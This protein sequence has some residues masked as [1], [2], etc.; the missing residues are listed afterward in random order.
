MGTDKLL[1]L[2]QQLFNR[3]SDRLR[4]VK[5]YAYRV[6]GSRASLVAAFH[7]APIIRNPSTLVFYFGES[8]SLAVCPIRMVDVPAPPCRTYKLGVQKP[9]TILRV[10]SSS[11]RNPIIEYAG[12]L[13]SVLVEDDAYTVAGVF[14]ST[15]SNGLAEIVANAAISCPYASEYIYSPIVEKMYVEVREALSE[16]IYELLE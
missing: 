7:Y 16:L 15:I 9:A 11:I 14:T 4:I 6:P 12:G 10:C 13:T 2:L 1:E 5:F 8:G 3:L